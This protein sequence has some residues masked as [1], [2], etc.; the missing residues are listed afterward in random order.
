MQLIVSEA[1]V[2]DEAVGLGSTDKIQGVVPVAI[3]DGGGIPMVVEQVSHDFQEVW[4]VIDDSDV[5]VVG[6]DFPVLGVRSIAR[7]RGV[8][9]EHNEWCLLTPPVR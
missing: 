4:V 9:N 7:D 1:E 5:R 6:H 8:A 3:N 2:D